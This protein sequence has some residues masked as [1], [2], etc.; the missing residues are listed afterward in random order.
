M[1]ESPSANIGAG[2]A[3]PVV[4]ILTVGLRFYTRRKM[5]NDLLMD[6]W[7]LVPALVRWC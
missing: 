6:D 5:K 2:V 4:G 7:L 1:D 3:M